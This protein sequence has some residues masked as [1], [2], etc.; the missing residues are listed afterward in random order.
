V[1]DLPG[2]LLQKKRDTMQRAGKLDFNSPEIFVSTSQQYT[3]MRDNNIHKRQ[4]QDLTL[5]RL[6]ALLDIRLTYK[7]ACLI[8]A[9]SGTL[10][11]FVK[12]NADGTTVITK[13]DR[14]GAYVCLIIDKNGPLPQESLKL[15]CSSIPNAMNL[16]IKW[17]HMCN[18]GGES[19]DLVLI[20]ALPTMPEDTFFAKYV[21][22]MSNNSIPGSGGWIYFCRTR[23]GCPGLWQHWFE[24]VV[25]PTIVRSANA[26]N[27]KVTYNSCMMTVLIGV[28]TLFCVGRMQMVHR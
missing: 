10:D 5:E 19:S 7:T 17:I 18:A 21:V 14:N 3:F 12:W 28:V 22:A 9:F 8:E 4:P 20:V 23:G 24:F 2:I 1:N 15:D 11:A 27:R 16:L 25:I 13:K 6:T 26:H